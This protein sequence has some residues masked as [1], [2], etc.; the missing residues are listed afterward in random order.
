[1]QAGC[2]QK[3]E[4]RDSDPTASRA[5]QSDEPSTEPGTAQHGT[6]VTAPVLIADRDDSTQ[7]SPPVEPVENS[8]E[9][10]PPPTLEQP[11]LEAPPADTEAQTVSA[12]SEGEPT[13]Q[14][15]SSQRAAWLLGSKLSMAALANDL[16]AAPDEVPAW[17]QEARAMA[18]LLQTSVADLPPRAE[19]TSKPTASR[20]VL[21]YLLDQGKQIGGQLAEQKGDDHAAL[22]EVAMKSNLLLVLYKPGS[23]AVGHISAAIEKAGPR[24][25]VPA[26]LWQPLLDT[27]S[28]DSPQ[29]AV[30]TAV[31]Q[32]H[33]E[34]DHHLASAGEEP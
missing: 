9:S 33:A 28:A 8:I 34:V 7:P 12:T 1:L 19:A 14:E 13:P 31:K 22:F 29:A 24:S 17:F 3:I 16:G 30:R 32:M 5:E 15:V 2:W 21:S 26:D 23:T 11:E 4:Y 27:L 25:G 18:E 10:P 20:Q 6:D